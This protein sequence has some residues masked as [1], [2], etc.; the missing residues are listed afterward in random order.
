MKNTYWDYFLCLL[1]FF[2][3][4]LVCTFDTRL[5]V[6]IVL[7]LYC[8]GLDCNTGPYKRENLSLPLEVSA[9]EGP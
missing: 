3:G 5:L 1:H 6:N 4:S 9:V 8:K 7:H 2:L